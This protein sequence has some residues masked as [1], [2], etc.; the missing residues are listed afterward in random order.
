[1]KVGSKI[2]FD[3]GNGMYEDKQ[4]FVVEEFRYCLGIFLSED[5]RVA[6]KF[7][8]LCEMY[9]SGPDSELKYLDSFGEYMTNQVQAWGDLANIK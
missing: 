4:V 5:H 9:E 7:T 8:P 3:V 1:M 2:L 6:Q